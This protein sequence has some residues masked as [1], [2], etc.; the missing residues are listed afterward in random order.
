MLPRLPPGP[1]KTGTRG[2]IDQIRISTH[3]R[4]EASF[5]RNPNSTIPYRQ[6][7]ENSPT[8]RTRLVNQGFTVAFSTFPPLDPGPQGISHRTASESLLSSYLKWTG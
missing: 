6:A 4:L 3:W 7:K 2:L 8:N 1:R 5:E